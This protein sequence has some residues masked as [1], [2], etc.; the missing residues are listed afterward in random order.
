MNKT[1]TTEWY[2][3][4]ESDR[5]VRPRHSDRI[6]F[7]THDRRPISG[8]CHVARTRWLVADHATRTAAR[9]SL[10]R[11]PNVI[12]HCALSM[13][14][15]SRDAHSM[16]PTATSLVT[17]RLAVSSYRR[18]TSTQTN[19]SFITRGRVCDEFREPHSHEPSRR[20]ANMTSAQSSQMCQ[21]KSQRRTKRELSCGSHW[22]ILRHRGQAAGTCECFWNNV[23]GDLWLL[24]QWD[25]RGLVTAPVH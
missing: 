18:G 8:K 21:N 9:A 1:S 14:Y 7:M 5:I 16:Q 6:L 19:V 3:N 4:V 2:K 13:Y 15:M 25:R 17:L 24:N 23:T 10:P 12:K 22:A 11:V 20:V